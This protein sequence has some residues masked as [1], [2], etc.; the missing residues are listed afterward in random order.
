MWIYLSRSGAL[1][2]SRRDVK[3]RLYAGRGEGMNNP[4]MQH[5]KGIGPLPE[6]L[7]TIE[8][9]HD[10]ATTGPYT[11]RLAPHLG[12]EMFGRASFAVHGASKSHPAESSH[13]CIIAGPQRRQML[14]ES[15]DRLLKVVAD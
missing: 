14:W 13:G 5:V 3:D 6:G 1:L 9:P 11:L 2:D 10:S 7:Y 15:G 8:A 12:N 4:D